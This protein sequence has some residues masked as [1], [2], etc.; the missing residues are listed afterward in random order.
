[1]SSDEVWHR[2]GRVR[3]NAELAE[4]RLASV[5]EAIASAHRRLDEWSDIWELRDGFWKRALAR[6]QLRLSFLWLSL[7][8]EANEACELE[9]EQIIRLE[10]RQDELELTARCARSD[11]DDL[12]H[13]AADFSHSRH[14]ANNVGS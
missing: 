11:Y 1:M 8:N 4:N 5:R 12:H 13:E 3:E 9:Q 6:R 7:R 2:L 14:E 10:H